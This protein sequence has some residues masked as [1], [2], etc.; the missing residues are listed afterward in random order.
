MNDLLLKI[1]LLS[2]YP[3]I[4]V[5]SFCLFYKKNKQIILSNYKYLIINTIV[6]SII[7]I[8]SIVV[9]FHFE[10]TI[11]SYDYSGHW[12]RALKIKQLFNTAP[13]K[14]L[15]TTYNSMNIDDYSYLPALFELPLFLFKNS[16]RWFVICNFVLFLLPTILLLEIYYYRFI[17]KYKFFPIILF[18]IFYPLYLPLF[19][20]KVDCIGVFFILMSYSLIIIPDFD[21]INILDNLSINIFAFVS[22][23]SRRWY[24]Y[25]IMCLY[26]SYLIKWILYK[27]KK[28]ND[29]FKLLS[30]GI[31]ALLIIVLF[32]KTF[33]LNA[34][35]NNFSEAYSF[36]DK[37]N[38]IF[39]FINYLSPIICVISVFGI[40]ELFKS[41][42]HLLFISLFSIALPCFMIWKIQSFE[43]HHYYIF[44]LNIIILFIYGLKLL[45]EYSKPLLFVCLLIA[46][47][48]P[49]A[50]FTFP[51][52]TL[53][54]FTNIRKYPEVLEN[55]TKLIEI[56]EYLR[57]IEPDNNT[58]AFLSAGTYGVITDDLLRN[59]L[60]PNLNSPNIDSSVFDIRDGF[61]RDFQFIKYIVTVTPMVY[62][63]QEYQHMFDIID[64][65]IKND[66]IVSSFYSPIYSA[67]LDEI[68]SVT[69]YE[70]IKELTPAVKR[71]FYNEMLQYYPDKAEYFKYILN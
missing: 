66:S 2:I 48:Q 52:N 6:I 36:Y 50:I 3:I 54:I 39:S 5:F 67:D 10:D 22:I 20:G 7:M 60:L 26:I 1:L 56:S 13:N 55:K 29:I 23:F 32:F 65:A 21:S 44:I 33:V 40:Y 70:R 51:N 59:A 63:D 62:T 15:P 16:Y 69:I 30:S 27:S 64:N 19:Y 61:P 24:L 53:P 58:S 68:H 4:L 38:K 46:I 57:S 37:K 12:I 9:F 42:R 18:I 35:N 45:L 47:I 31:F 71:Y 14:I 34:A 17:D 28:R 43:Y 49:I 25:S 41:N 8:V 11:Y